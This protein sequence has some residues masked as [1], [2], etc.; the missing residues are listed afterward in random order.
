MNV[1]DM[2]ESAA[3]EAEAMMDG[4]PDFELVSG[5]TAAPAVRRLRRRSAPLWAPAAPLGAL[6]APVLGGLPAPKNCRILGLAT[7]LGIPIYNNLRG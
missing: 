2:E 1:V 5:K 4:G 7:M 6:R 3:A